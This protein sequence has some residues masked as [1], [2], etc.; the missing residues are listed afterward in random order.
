VEEYLEARP[1]S[2]IEVRNPFV[3]KNLIEAICDM[4]NNE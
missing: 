3:Q 4:N 1:L 2:I